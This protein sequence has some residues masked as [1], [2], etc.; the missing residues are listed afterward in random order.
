MY[1]KNYKIK[2]EQIEDLVPGMGYCL[3]TDKIITDG[4]P[5]GYMFR[6]DREDDSD[7]GWRFF[8]GTEDEEYTENEENFGMYDVNTIA[9]YDRS[10]LPFLKHPV[11]TELERNEETGKWQKVIYEDE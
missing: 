11:G 2:P 6:E 10:I 9:N 4:E 7:S 1:R 8:S 5:V 3:A